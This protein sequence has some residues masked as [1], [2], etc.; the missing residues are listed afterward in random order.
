[1]IP[2]QIRSLVKESLVT[3]LDWD[4]DLD[5]DSHVDWSEAG[6]SDFGLGAR[7]LLDSHMVRMDEGRAEERRVEW[8][9]RT[10]MPRTAWSLD[11]CFETAARAWNE[12]QCT[13]AGG[14]TSRRRS[15][16]LSM[17]VLDICYT[18]S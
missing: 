2:L 10:L 9:V 17:N 18:L 4:S 12:L 5:A 13:P 7:V 8:G 11:V 3:P 16:R 6:P 14:E 15:C 1:M